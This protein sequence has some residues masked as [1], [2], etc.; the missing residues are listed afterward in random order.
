[1][2]MYM[3]DSGA[4]D[5]SSTIFDHATLESIFQHGKERFTH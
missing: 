5:T 1:M 2:H 3:R 4:F